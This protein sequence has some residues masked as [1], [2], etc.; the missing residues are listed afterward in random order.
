M[1]N[2]IAS[3]P[4]IKIRSYLLHLTHYDPPWS[5]DKSKEQPFELPVAL[6][7]VD[8]L[9][10]VGFNT[11][12]V[13]VSDGVEYKSHPEF[14]RHYSVPMEQLNEL[15]AYARGKGLDIIPKLNFSR[16]AINCHNHWMRA[17]GQ[18]WHVHFDDP[19]YW[20]T[21]FEVIDELIGVCQPKHYFHVGMDEDHDRSYTQFVDALLV[22]H[23]GLTK[24]QLRTVA[25]SDSSLDYPSGQIYREKSELAETRLPKDCIRILWNYWAQPAATMQQITNQ[26]LELWG[27]P[28][29]KDAAQVTGFKNALLAAGGNGLIMTRWIACQKCN[30][31]QLIKQIRELGP[32]YH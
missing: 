24:R 12:V 29:W 1:N 3:N 13:G 14:K 28:G 5:A 18:E 8:E 9:V 17:P 2:S 10:K 20:A 15:C 22:L 6:S 19:H 4:S 16:S 11:L 31:E 32:L 23:E 7:L 27:A 30:Q 26:G 25:W 21:A